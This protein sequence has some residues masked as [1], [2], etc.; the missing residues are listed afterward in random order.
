MRTTTN[1]TIGKRENQMVPV[2]TIT[3]RG[4]RRL[5]T[6]HPWIYRSDVADARAKPGDRVVVYGS[7]G[8]VLGEALYSDRSQIA[9]RMLTYGD[10][11][12]DDALIRRR[13]ENAVSFRRSLE[14]TATAFRLVHG[15]ADRL[16]SIVVD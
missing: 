15:E 5:T 14:I 12:A 1:C 16:P 9:L 6:G 2:V 10:E 13:I 3:S 8:R 7:R 11:P 4:E